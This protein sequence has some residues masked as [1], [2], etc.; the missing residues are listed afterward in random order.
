MRRT[1]SAA[2]REHRVLDR[3]QMELVEDSL[4]AMK[5][6]PA[7]GSRDFCKNV[8]GVNKMKRRPPGCRWSRSVSDIRNYRENTG[9]R[10]LVMV[11]LASVERWPDLKLEVLQTVAAF[12]RGLDGNDSAIRPG[13]ALRLRRDHR[14]RALRQLHAKPRGGHSRR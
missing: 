11:N 5:P 10:N 7:V 2:V 12:E 4:S 6:W 9:V 3:E 13:D 14:G 8:D 1:L